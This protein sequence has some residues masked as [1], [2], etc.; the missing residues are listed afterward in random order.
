[1]SETNGNISVIA[2]KL[3]DLQKLP[4]DE[5]IFKNMLNASEL[6]ITRQPQ[7]LVGGIDS[8]DNL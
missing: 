5:T 6:V 8:S 7:G 1:M 3:A 4:P 2:S